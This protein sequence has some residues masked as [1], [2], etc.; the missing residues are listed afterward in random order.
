MQLLERL[1]YH[2]QHIQEDFYANSTWNDKQ[3]YVLQDPSPNEYRRELK[4]APLRALEYKGSWYFWNAYDALH[5]EVART[6][7][8][9]G[10]SR[11]DWYSCLVIDKD[12]ALNLKE[13]EFIWNQVRAE[14]LGKAE[15]RYIAGQILKQLKFLRRKYGLRIDQEDVRVLTRE[16]FA[17]LLP[18]TEKERYDATHNKQDRANYRY[19]AGGGEKE[20]AYFDKKYGTFNY[21]DDANYDL[22]DLEDVISDILFKN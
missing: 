19:R 2:I 6:L 7:K 21:K 12:N 13:M 14:S 5:S 15:A 10:F 17:K 1:Q 22:G 9:G 20:K 8:P 3:A 4:I 11:H 18:P 16:L